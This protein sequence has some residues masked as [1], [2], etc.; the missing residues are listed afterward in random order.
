MRQ[1]EDKQLIQRLRPLIGNHYH[2]LEQE[3]SLI[4]ILADEGSLVLSSLAEEP[5]IQADQYGSAARRGPETLLIPIFNQHED[6][7]S[8]ELQELL[9]SKLPDA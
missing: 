1:I 5:T 3:W 9:S 6:R 2:Y 7:Y 4:E 8:D